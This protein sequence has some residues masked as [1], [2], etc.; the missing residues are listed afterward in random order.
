MSIYEKS[1]SQLF[2][3]MA[4]DMQL[5]LGDTIIKEDGVNWFKEKYPLVKESTVIAH[6]NRMSVNSTSRHHT[7]FKPVIDDL[8]YKINSHTYRL[9]DQEN[10][11]PPFHQTREKSIGETV[12]ETPNYPTTIG[13]PEESKEFAYER[14]LQ[15]F[16]I[17]NLH[18]IEEGLK[19]YED[20][21][22]K[23]IEFP[24]GG[25]YID[26]LAV[27]KNNDYVVIELK[28]SKGYDRVIGQLLRYVSWIR[29]NLADEGQKVRGVIIAREISEDLK[30]AC[31]EIPNID[32][33]EYQMSIE[34]SKLDLT[35]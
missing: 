9:Y 2:W 14:D 7:S 19:L 6:F 35:D 24:V 28:V 5:K 23:G 30:L 26:I 11:P 17:K 18:L 16:L 15:N 1:V 8:L 22:I 13:E 12:R 32:L 3:D 4:K 20:E 29:K 31:G 21:G 33:F 27:D 25:R 34:L 10:D